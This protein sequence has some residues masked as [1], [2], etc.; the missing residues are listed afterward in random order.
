MSTVSFLAQLDSFLALARLESL[1]AECFPLTYDINGFKS[2]VNRHLF[3]LGSFYTVFL[4][5]F[6]LFL[7]F[8]V[9]RNGCS[10]LHGIKKKLACHQAS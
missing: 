7:L 3:S 1:P 5:D 10:A 8:L 6:H 2:R 4:Y 9:A